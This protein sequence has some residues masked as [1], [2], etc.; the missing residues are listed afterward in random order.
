MNAPIQAIRG[1]NDILPEETPRWQHL[2]QLTRDWL[3]AWGYHEIRTPIIEQTGLFKRA[4][5]EV[6]DI[7]EKEMYSFTDA[8]NGEQLS[9][10]PEGTAA[11]VRAVVQH[12]LL[13]Q[14]AQRLWYSGPMFRHERPQKGRYRQFHQIGVEAMG[15][16][17]A[18]MDAEHIVMTADLWRRIGL[19]GIRLELNTLGDGD[20]RA[21]FRNR[22]IDWFESHAD[23][24]DDDA[25]RR[26]HTNPLRILDS[27]NPAM[28]ALIEAA[29]RLEHDL[30][31]AARAHFETVQRI[32]RAHDIEFRLNHRLVRGLD[33]YNYTVFEWITDELGAQGTVCAG[34][35]YDGLIGQ[36]GGKPHPACGYAI[37][38]ER[39][40]ALMEHAGIVPVDAGPDAYVVFAGTHAEA[41][42]WQ[43]ARSLREA[44]LRVVL[45]CGGGSFKSQ[46]KKADASGAR[47][48][49]IIG[50][51]EAASGQISLKPLRDAREQARMP[52]EHVISTLLSKDC[53]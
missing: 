53:A 52:V 19:G 51:D 31:D 29:P 48:A 18:D 21:R 43:S 2:E 5:G 50:D 39:L 42:A 12:N 17:D 30:D 49:C 34:G 7:V 38:I 14:S 10:R 22:L 25:R 4:I 11:C 13:Y 8:L 45:H 16:A 15:Y 24:L 47:F 46:M 32:V 37:G 36:I 26:L 1:M 23:Q 44:G 41:F 27:K 33:Y 35:R 9:L 3:S 40:L 28:Q 20:A 6:T